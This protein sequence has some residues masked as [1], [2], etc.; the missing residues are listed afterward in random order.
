MNQYSES[1]KLKLATC[2]PRLQKLFYAVLEII[3]HTILEG[4]R[5]QATQDKYF[6]EGTTKLKWPDGKHNK[7]PSLA[8][9]ATPY[10]VN[11]R[12]NNR[13]CYFAGVVCGMAQ[14]MGL[15]IRWGGDF[16]RDTLVFEKRT[17]IDAFH[18]ELDD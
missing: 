3:D 14:S 18:F 2:D 15:K 13:I 10:P 8:V 4:T 11:L 17:F 7:V 16:D 5:D 12:D 9:D 6:A 1:S